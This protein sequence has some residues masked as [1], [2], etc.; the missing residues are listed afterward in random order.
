MYACE[1]SQRVA[2]VSL[3]SPLEAGDAEGSEDMPTHVTFLTPTCLAMAR[4]HVVKVG[5]MKVRT[6]V[7]SAFVVLYLIMGISH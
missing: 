6:S 3:P 5:L 7:S 1:G 4:G 2:H